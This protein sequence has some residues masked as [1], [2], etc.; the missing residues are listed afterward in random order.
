ML[1]LRFGIV[2]LCS[3]ERFVRLDMFVGVL[4]LMFISSGVVDMMLW[5]LIG[6]VFVVFVKFVCLVFVIFEFY[7][8]KRFIVDYFLFV[9]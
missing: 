4:G 5:L 3:G 6:E 9:M 8:I 2:W 7:I 1:V